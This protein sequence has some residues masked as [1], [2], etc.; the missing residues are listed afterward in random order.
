MIYDLLGQDNIILL[1]ICNL[2]VQN[3]D[4][5]VFKMYMKFLVYITNRKLSS[6][7]FTIQYFLN[8]FMEHDLHLIF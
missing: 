3:T 1:K 8:L 7:I 4:K 6:D 5:I 2:R